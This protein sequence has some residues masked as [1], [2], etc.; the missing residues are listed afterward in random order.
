M[1]I[2]FTV[3]VFMP[4]W[5]FGTEIYTYT[6]A[7]SMQKQGHAVQVVT[8]ESN[9]W[10]DSAEVTAEDDVWG[11]VPVH[12]LYFNVM[13]TENPTRSDYYNTKVEEH[14]L[15][16]FARK[17]PDLIHACHTGHLSTAVVTA[18]KRL[19][20]PVIATATDF[21]YICPNS[22][23]LRYDQALC[24]GPTSMSRCVRCYIY[25]RDLAQR[26]RRIVDLIPAPLLD[27]AISICRYPWA[28]H[29]WRTK[30]VR[31]VLQRPAWMRYILNSI[32]LI[33]SPSQFLRDLFVKNGVD[34][35]KIRVSPHGIDASW[36]EEMLSKKPSDHLRFVFIGMLG[37][38]KGPH[39][40]V[41]AFNQLPNP[42]G[43]TLKLYG[44]SE[45]FADYFRD[46]QGLME[47]NTRISYMGKFSHEKIGE[48]LSEVDVLVIPS[49][50][51]ENTPVVMYEAFA[52]KTPVI[53]TNSGGMAELISLFDG[54][55]VFERGNVAQLAS[56][57]QRLIDGP[58][59]VAEA[60]RR[61]KPVRKIEEHIADL[62]RAY[63]EVVGKSHQAPLHR[64]KAFRGG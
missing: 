8:C 47:G 22:Q 3:H 17:G 59:L 2:I 61:I 48:V 1:K 18:A 34:P 21:W 62:E 5:T 45:H 11:G 54:G 44:D 53:A 19:N 25:Q 63:K 60:N 27:L 56:L 32:D 52:T 42:Q 36:A 58:S 49:M 10:G 50:W 7:K 26:Y 14:L 57:M 51:Y 43:A 33:F 9:M 4:K 12:R 15:D 31:A 37:W 20:I 30:L 23:L 40:L 28:N 64:D 46:L 6:L 16:Y 38:H 41:K 13:Q 39:I 29:D 35:R 55:W 24:K